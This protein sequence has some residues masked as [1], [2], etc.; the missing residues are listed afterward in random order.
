VMI[1]LPMNMDY[2]H[3]RGYE[4]RM[5]YEEVDGKK[6]WWDAKEGEYKKISEEDY[7]SY[8]K[9]F[10]QK[11]KIKTTFYESKGLILSFFHYDPRAH[12]KNW[13]GPF[14][15]NLIHTAKETAFLENFPAIGIK[16]YTALGYQPDDPLLNFPWDDYYYYCEEMKIPIICHCSRGGMITHD[17]LHYYDHAFPRSTHAPDSLKRHWFLNEFVSPYAWE[18]VLK[19]HEKLFFCFAHFGGDTF[20]DK[21]ANPQCDVYWKDLSDLDPDNWIAGFL[22]LMSRYDNVYIDLAYFM[23]KPSM[24]GYFKKA[25]GFNNRIKHKILF[26]TDWWMFTREERYK[27]NEDG[28]RLYVEDM[29]N[30]IISIDDKDFLKNIGVKSSSELLA[31]FMVLNPMR[32]LG[33]KQIV[34]KLQEIFNKYHNGNESFELNE[35]IN[36][37]PETIE[38]FYS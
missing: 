24:I 27:H 2:A 30:A 15:S 17:V 18:P 33:L 23:L 38:D 3:F 16:M 14:N 35:W 25:L 7:K 37:V 12:L 21:E 13:M 8:E 20:W 29:C 6:C 1:N 32:F 28:Y 10:D 36:S 31:Y 11:I 34:P 9:Y 4:G 5:V 19:K 26:G 22:D